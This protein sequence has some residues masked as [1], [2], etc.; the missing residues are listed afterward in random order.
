MF[1]F[2][3]FLIGG[4]VIGLTSF[5]GLYDS[6]QAMAWAT[7]KGT[8]TELKFSHSSGSG[9]ASTSAR[10]IEYS[11]IVKGK[12]YTGNREYFGLLTAT[13]KETNG[14]Y[15]VGTSVKVY[16]N[17]SY[18][19]SS[20][21][22]PDNRRSLWFNLVIAFVFGAFGGYGVYKIKKEDTNL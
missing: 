10:H 20:V 4:L 15:L 12:K 14:G 13:N 16:Y 6:Y 2:G 1:M 9:K 17:P 18:P 22:K 8:I 5:K 19:V 7:T 3:L 11:Y 21:L